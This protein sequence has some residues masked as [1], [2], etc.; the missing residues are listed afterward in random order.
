MGS[1]GHE[2]NG[3][4][5][6][7]K[8]GVCCLE[9]GADLWYGLLLLDFAVCEGGCCCWCSISAQDISCLDIPPTETS[10]LAVSAISTLQYQILRGYDSMVDTFERAK[11]L[12]LF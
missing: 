9:I 6:G 1:H 5:L 7:E 2:G 8:H 11:H 12:L 4:D 3:A 10:F